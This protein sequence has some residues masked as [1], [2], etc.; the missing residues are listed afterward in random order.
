MDFSHFI[1]TDVSK[2]ELDIAVY[3]EKELLYHEQ[4]SNEPK[5][6]KKFLKELNKIEGFS[7]SKTLFAW[8]SLGY[9][10]II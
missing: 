9:T 6:I 1:G 8:N 4:I 10:T 7:L 3:Q 5:A 2:N